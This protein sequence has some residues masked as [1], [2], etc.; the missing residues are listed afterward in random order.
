VENG[1]TETALKMG[2][3]ILLALGTP[4]D[5]VRDVKAQ[6]RA[7]Y[8]ALEEND[9]ERRKQLK[10]KPSAAKKSIEIIDKTSARVRMLTNKLMYGT[11]DEELSRVLNEVSKSL[12]D[13]FELAP[14]RAVG[15]DS[16]ADEVDDADLGVLVCILPQKE[17][18]TAAG[19]SAPDISV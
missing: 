6:L 2:E 19:S 1:Q 16:P 14:D 15:K 7:D 8:L 9:G 5:D 17:K 12:E 11:M 10:L 18:E 3:S 13:K 4:V